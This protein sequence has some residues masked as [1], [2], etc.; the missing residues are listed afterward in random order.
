[1][2]FLLS[3]EGPSDLGSEEIDG[4]LKKGPMT[5]VVDTLCAQNNKPVPNYVGWLSHAKLSK[6][7]AKITR[8]APERPDK[9]GGAAIYDQARALAMQAKE[10]GENCGAVFFCD[11]DR[12]ARERSQAKWDTLY[13]AMKMGFTDETMGHLGIPMIPNPRSEAWFLAYY[14][15]NEPGQQAYN[16]SERF[17]EMSGNDSSPKS[18]KKR[19]ASLLGCAENEIYDR[20]TEEA[21]HAIDWNR[22]NMKSFNQFKMDLFVVLENSLHP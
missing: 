19:L 22:V 3:G 6:L 16:H 12:N 17:E 15:K 8:G 18:V 13:K 10:K 2:D 20:I 1:M 5:Y 11:C 21:I 7:A 14:Q 4:S 9:K